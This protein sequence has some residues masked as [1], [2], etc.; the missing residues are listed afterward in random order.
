MKFNEGKAYKLD[1]QKMDLSYGVFGKLLVI[2]NPTKTQFNALYT[3]VKDIRGLVTLD[4]CY[5]WDANAATHD[6]VKKA[7]KDQ[8]AIEIEDTYCGFIYTNEKL[9]VDGYT[10]L[11]TKNYD[12][13]PNEKYAKTIMLKNSCII[14]IFD[15]D[16][17]INAKNH[18][19]L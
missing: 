19:S 13:D 6:A 7:L 2:E 3:I 8:E 15:K 14:N 11:K 18:H 4:K 17:I 12:T 16:L 9:G 5:I 1:K 10:Y